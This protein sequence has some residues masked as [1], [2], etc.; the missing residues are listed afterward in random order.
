MHQPSPN[1]KCSHMINDLVSGLFTRAFTTCVS[2]EFYFVIFM[3]N[4]A[5]GINEL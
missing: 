4:S 1:V 2:L 3:L 5:R